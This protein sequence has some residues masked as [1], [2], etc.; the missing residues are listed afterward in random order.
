MTEVYRKRGSVVRW[1]NG[2]TVRVNESGEA[3]DDG[4]TFVARPSG[5]RMVGFETNIKPPPL[6]AERLILTDGLAEHECNGIA[7]SE[8]TRRMHVALTGGAHRAILDLAEF[9]FDLVQRVAD[10]LACAG[11]EREPPPRIRLAPH[12]T[13]ALLPSLIGAID[14]DQAPAPHDGRGNAIVETCV[15]GKPPNVWRPSYRVRP[16]PLWHNLRA[17]PFGVVD[18]GAIEAMALLNG[19]LLLE[20]G[21]ICALRIE[22]VVAVG[23]PQSWFPI[24]AGSFGAE[25]LL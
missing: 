5:A 16:L 25:M 9:D 4:K 3:I 18:R 7:W 12:V 11:G 13:A 6:S 23:E 14:I 8:R 1:E 17:R 20:D 22:R 21:S 10:I 19:R 2:W 24:G 15:E